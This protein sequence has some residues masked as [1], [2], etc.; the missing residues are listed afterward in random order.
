MTI[1]NAINNTSNTLSTTLVTG[2]EIRN[3]S[4]TAVAVTATSTTQLNLSN[5][6]LFVLT[7]AV[8]ITTMQ[9]QN[10]QPTNE[11][12]SFTIKRVKDNS[13]TARTITW[14]ASV[15]WPGGTAPTLTA[16]ANAVDILTFFTHDNGTTWYGFT[17][18][19][20]MA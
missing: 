13:A 19:L 11:V 15:K 18:G 9:F 16:T 12:S 8:D 5:G 20:A 10:P 3:Y 6:N 4:E 14:P 7:Q 17:A 2:A 1:T